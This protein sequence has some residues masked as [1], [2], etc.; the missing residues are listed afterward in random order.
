MTHTSNI[1]ENRDFAVAGMTCSH[2]A[3]YEV[4]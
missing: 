2:C 1:N 4:V 3:G